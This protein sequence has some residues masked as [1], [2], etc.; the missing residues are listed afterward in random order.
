MT[1]PLPPGARPRLRGEALRAKRD[2]SVAELMA[3]RAKEFDPGGPLDLNSADQFKVGSANQMASMLAEWDIKAALPVLKARAERFAGLLQ[4]Q[5]ENGPKIFGLEERIESLTRLRTQAGDPQALDDYAGW[6]RTITPAQHDARQIAIFEPLWSNPDHPAVIAAA[7]ALF[8]DPKSPWNPSVS[9]QSVATHFRLSGPLLGLKSFRTLVLR[10]LADKTQVGTVEV[11]D[12][13]TVTVIQGSSKTV[14]KSNSTSQSVISVGTLSSRPE[15]PV[16]PGPRAMPLRMADLVCEDLQELEGIP[17]FLKQW[18]VSKRDQAIGACM[19]YL[20]QFGER[21]H[22]NAASRAIRAAEPGGPRHE[23]AVLAFDPL[24]HPATAEEVVGGPGHLLARPCRGRSPPR[25]V[26]GAPARRPVD[27]AGGLPRRSPRITMYDEEGQEIPATEALQEGRVWQAEEVRVGDG[28]RR[29]FG[30][31]GRHALTRVA[32]EEIEFLTPWQQGWS[33]LS[34]DLDARIEIKEAATAGPV[35]VE[36]SFRN[37]RGVDSIGSGRARPSC[38]RHGH[39]PRRHRLPARPRVGQSRRAQPVCPVGRRSREA[40]PPRGD[41]RPPLPSP[42]AWGL[43]PDTGAGRDGQ[44][45]STRPSHPISHRTARP[46]PIGHH[47]RRPED[48]R[49]NAWKSRNDFPRRRPEDRVKDCT[50]GNQLGDVANHPRQEAE[51]LLPPLGRG[52]WLC[53]ARVQNIR[54]E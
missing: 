38:R 52:A 5:R 23:R 2:P 17:R 44:R 20:K 9:S 1:T 7:A 54:W 29:Y 46:L 25:P 6:I 33:L 40:I 28:W 31:V 10:A 4:A 42:S 14:E 16:K 48:G 11:D 49:G 19:A 47:L 18:P 21:F 51:P 50:G 45:V 12:E 3:M 41:P 37:H 30:F 8:E 26:A 32:A 43:A 13:G 53:P 22:A 36:L 34:T 35:P 27:E 39:D 24:D 15:N